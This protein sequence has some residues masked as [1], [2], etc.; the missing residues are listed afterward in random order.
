MSD[1]LLGFGPPLRYVPKS[2]PEA[3]R[4]GH[5][6]WGSLPLQRMRRRESTARRTDGLPG[7]PGFRRQSHPPATVPL[8][9]F[10]SP[11]AASSSLRRPAIFRRVALLGFSPFRDFIRPHRPRDSSPPACPLDV[12]PVGWPLPVLGGEA[13]GRAASQPRFHWP[14]PFSVFRAFVRTSVDLHRQPMS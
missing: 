7:C 10:R 4:L 11:S 12:P 9:G 14:A 3:S 5:L 8:T 2:P 13:S 6:S 1:P